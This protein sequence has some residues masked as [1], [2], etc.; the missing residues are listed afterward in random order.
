M[1]GGESSHEP[2]AGKAA[3]QQKGYTMPNEE[4]ITKACQAAGITE[5]VHTFAAWKALGFSVKK[6]EHA[7]LKLPIW[8]YKARKVNDADSEDKEVGDTFRVTAFFF[9][10]HQVEPI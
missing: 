6:G 4:I 10:L 8:R 7:L 2:Q 3:R 9:G 1:R 5:T